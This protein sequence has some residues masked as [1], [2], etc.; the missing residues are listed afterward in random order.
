MSDKLV[1]RI[2]ELS[3]ENERLKAEL[4]RSERERLELLDHRRRDE[5]QRGAALELLREF[6]WILDD[7]DEYPEC[8]Q[9]GDSQD[10]G[11]AKGCRL[12]AFLKGQDT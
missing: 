8:P 2:A 1:L 4:S 10:M 9:C 7:R 11:H 3:G 6:E 12:A 5:Q